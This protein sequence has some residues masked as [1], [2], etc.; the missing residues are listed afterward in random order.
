MKYLVNVLLVLSGMFI[1]YGLSAQS[2][3]R[4]D[5]KTQLP[6]DGYVSKGEVSIEAVLDNKDDTTTII[7][8][9]CGATVTATVHNDLIRGNDKVSEAA[10][11][12]AI[13][14]ACATVMASGK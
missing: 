14:Q 9:A 3:K 4:Y 12:Q 13:E 6:K 11:N 2:A 8:D 1:G 7:I 5:I 10:V